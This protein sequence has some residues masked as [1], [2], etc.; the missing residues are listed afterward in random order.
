MA[1]EVGAPDGTRWKVGRALLRGTD[2]HGRRLKWRGPSLDILE[3]ARFADLADLSEVPVL[4]AIG[5]AVAIF[6]LVVLAL[7]LLPAIAL[8]L[9]QALILAVLFVLALVAATLFGRPILV[10]AEQP[11]TGASLVWAA[12]G[13][14][15]S[16][17]VRDQ[18]A[19]ALRAGLNPIDA[20]TSDATLIAQREGSVPDESA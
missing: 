2:G 7:L 5:L 8:G 11:S 13:W 20:V 6:V 17:E 3:F 1:V 4:G 14:S 18:V 10:R 19:D 9:I 16:R 15:T 12:K